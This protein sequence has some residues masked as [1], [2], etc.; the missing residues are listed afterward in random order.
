MG[1]IQE[2]KEFTVTSDDDKRENWEPSDKA[3]KRLAEA[4]TAPT[5]RGNCANAGKRQVTRRPKGTKS[6]CLD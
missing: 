1:G 2:E 6:Q 4:F 3:E 5:K